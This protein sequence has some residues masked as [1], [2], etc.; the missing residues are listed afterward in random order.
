[1]AF[2][3]RLKTKPGYRYLLG[4]SIIIGFFWIMK[5]LAPVIYV[6]SDGDIYKVNDNYLDVPNQ[7][8]EL[9][10]EAGEVIYDK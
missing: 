4:L 7:N 8:A 3:E 5:V 10:R 2:T 6:N 9:F 1:M